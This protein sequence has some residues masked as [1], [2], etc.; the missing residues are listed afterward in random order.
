MTEEVSGISFFGSSQGWAHA[1][2]SKAF[3]DLNM[4]Q[5]YNKELVY[6]DNMR[7]QQ[8]EAASKSKGIAK[9]TTGSGKKLSSCTVSLS[10]AAVYIACTFVQAFPLIMP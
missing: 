9:Y 6:A 2:M 7:L 10:Q 5:F 1:T 3:K 4:T 8:Q